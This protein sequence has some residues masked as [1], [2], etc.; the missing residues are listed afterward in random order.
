MTFFKCS[1]IFI[2]SFKINNSWASALF[3][4]DL[5]LINRITF[6]MLDS[7]ISLLLTKLIGY[8]LRSIA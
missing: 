3:L 7:F 4:N 5:T 6:Q 2:V 8:L 1:I